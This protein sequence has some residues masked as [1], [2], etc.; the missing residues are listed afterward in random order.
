MDVSESPAV[1]GLQI[2]NETSEIGGYGF[3]RVSECQ[4]AAEPVLRSP[5]IIPK[6]PVLV[7]FLITIWVSLGVIWLVISVFVFCATK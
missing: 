6:L 7:G 4:P 2:P 3:S 5:G 1:D